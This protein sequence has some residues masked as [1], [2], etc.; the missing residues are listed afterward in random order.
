MMVLL[1][2]AAAL[3]AL[4]LWP[5]FSRA[6]ESGIDNTA[7]AA[8][9][10]LVLVVVGGGYW[11]SGDPRG[12]DPDSVTEVAPTAPDI[13]AMIVQLETR[14]AEQPA[15]LEGWGMLA[16]SYMVLSRFSDAHD[17]YARVLTLTGGDTVE[18]RVS[19]A[20][21]SVLVSP[22][23]L[24]GEAGALFEQ[25]LEMD[26]DQSKALWYGG[27]AAWRR[28]ESELGEARWRRL[29]EQGPPEE[30]AMII[31]QRLG[32]TETGPQIEA[33]LTVQISLATELADQIAPDDILFLYARRPEGGPPLAVKRLSG[34]EL[35]IVVQLGASDDPM[36]QGAPLTA[37]LEIV[38]RLSATGD[39]TPQSG[40]RGGRV[41]LEEIPDGP[42]QITIDQ[43]T[44]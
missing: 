19:Y 42:I 3:S 36:G 41:L 32:G 2:L 34:S 27:I 28:G 14:L 43:V 6:R 11:I 23:A 40:D 39:A 33:V 37:P 10:A 44:P 15:D 8:G 24:D 26:P 29:L 20:E 30:L 16:R 12:L 35:P 25:A 18:N 22:E 17:A 4:L 38:A 1:T 7:N 9:I 21:A 31:R 13:S 5:V